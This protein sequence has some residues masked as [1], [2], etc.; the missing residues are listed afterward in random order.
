[1][2]AMINKKSIIYDIINPCKLAETDRSQAYVESE[3]SSYTGGSGEIRFSLPSSE[4]MDL[5]ESYIDALVI[6]NTTDTA[7]DAE[8]ELNLTGVTAGTYRFEYLGK[9]SA[10]LN[11]N[12]TDVQIQ[13]A[14]NNMSSIRGLNFSCVVVG[15]GPTWT[16]V[17]SGNQETPFG[18][19]D[20]MTFLEQSTLTGL[21]GSP[22]YQTIQGDFAFPRVD[23]LN[24]V[25]RQVRV[26]VNAQQFITI[27]DA[28]VLSNMITLFK[29]IPRQYGEYNMNNQRNYGMRDDNQFRIRIELDHVDFLKK[30]LPLSVM[31]KQFR[32]FLQ[33]ELPNLA[34]IQGPS[35][36][37]TYTIQ[38][39]RLHYHRL[40]IADSEMET[41]RNAYVNGGLVIPFQNWTVFT[42]SI[43]SG[44]GNKNILFNPGV[45]NL[46]ATFFVMLPEEYRS[47]PENLGKTSVF[48]R[49]RIGSYRLKCG[50]SYFP[51]DQI[52]SVNP[53]NRDMVEPISELEHAIANI[54]HID[55]VGY[56]R[57]IYFNYI[58]GGDGNL[59]TD[60]V[61]DI[62][63]GTLRR[64][65]FV[66]GI[67]TADTPHTQYGYVCR[68]DALSGQDVSNLS[69]VSLEL[70]DLSLTQDNTIVI[71]ALHQD[72]LVLTPKEA[73]WIK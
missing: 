66:G 5:T 14:V 55:E 56:D 47:N 21:A 54:L 27:T 37:G 35:G 23:F 25:I 60:V 45:S 50:S 19:D 42:D 59:P 69:N 15:A 2:S 73:R 1:M 58:G 31:N 40:S 29:P 16:L 6:L 33:T 38:N 46:L 44:T 32:I 68:S 4:T 36:G 34:L 49:N 10:I 12:S 62:T 28:N 67:S 24:P 70:K 11:Y 48:L 43:S 63:F 52:D 17:F 22:F 53:G 57:Q 39:P 20:G 64:P 41:L 8:Y 51:L 71:Y 30:I 9:V 65:T 61:L 3:A 72:F 7:V 18:Y 26:E 13:A